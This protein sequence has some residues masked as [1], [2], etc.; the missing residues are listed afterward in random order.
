MTPNRDNPLISVMMPA[1]N[2]AEYINEA[3][4]SLLAQTY[5]HW[6]LIVVN[7]GSTDETAAVLGQCDD[8]R[9]RV[10]HKENGG[11]A[12]ARNVALSHMSGDLLAFL[13]A[14]D[15]FLPHH[16][17]TAV[18]HLQQQPQRNAVYSDGYYINQNGAKLQPLSSQRRGPFT[19][20]LFEQLAH[21]S[22]VFGPPTCVVLT[23]QIVVEQRLT[24]DPQIV[25][26]PD[27]DFLTHYAQF[28]DFA[29]ADE[30]TCLYRV[31]QTNVTVRVNLAERA[32]HTA[33]CREKAIQLPRFADCSLATQTAVFYD[34]LVNMLNGHPER[35]T[36]VLAW[37]QFQA[38]PSQEQARLLRLMFREGLLGDTDG[39]YLDD[40]LGQARCRDPA[41]RRGT[42]V[43]ALYRLHPALCRLFLRARD[44]AQPKETPISPFQNLNQS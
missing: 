21:A 2:A 31:H 33:R 43:A 41:D 19:G 32:L 38:L 20:D 25:I 36:A 42:W 26:G 29:Y 6:E 1:Y 3:I 17:A 13:D 15:V 10:F 34:L 8:P 22:D 14:D 40:W 24:F 23:R 28:G 44:F 30:I 12:S 16:L 4:D 27:W 11:E 35:Q 9:I 39:R 5:P 7:D 18:T 37:P